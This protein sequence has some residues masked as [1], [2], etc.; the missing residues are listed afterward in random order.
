M[1]KSIDKNYRET[2]DRA[3]VLVEKIGHNGNMYILTVGGQIYD[4]HKLSGYYGVRWEIVDT[5]LDVQYIRGLFEL[6]KEP[7]R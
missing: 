2:I 3:A 4:V 1:N 6:D 5:S 7:K